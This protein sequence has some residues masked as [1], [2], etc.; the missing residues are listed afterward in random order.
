MGFPKMTAI[1]VG[2]LAATLTLGGGA[3]AVSAAQTAH[4]APNPDRQA[5]CQEYQD[6]FAQN[7][8][9]TAQK[10]EDARKATA[11]QIIDE[12]L[13]AS[14]ITQEQAQKAHERVNSGAGACAAAGQANAGPRHQATKEFRQVELKAVAQ[15]LGISEQELVK[16]LRGG[17]S[18]AQVAQAHKVGR[19]DLK[20]TM[21]TALQTALTTQVQAGKVTQQQ[22]DKALAAF[23]KHADALIDR[24]WQAK[25]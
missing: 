7:L 13:A 24:V 21:R 3:A 18:L 19:D 9:V 12:R 8:G 17:K 6:K 23:D 4:A 5:A 16:E 20:A 1:G 11:N 25:Q 15:K 22:A 2:L 10:L 14:Q